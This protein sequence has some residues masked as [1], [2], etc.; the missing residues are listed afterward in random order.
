MKVTFVMEYDGQEYTKQ[1]DVNVRGNI[2]KIEEKIKSYIGK[3][4]KLIRI[5]KVEYD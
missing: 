5:V 4:S 3:E 2:N 1:I